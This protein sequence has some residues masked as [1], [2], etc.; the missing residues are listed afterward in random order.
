MDVNPQALEQCDFKQDM[1][2]GVDLKSF[3]NILEVIDSNS[4]VQIQIDDSKA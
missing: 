1:Q 4:K 2:I 3:N